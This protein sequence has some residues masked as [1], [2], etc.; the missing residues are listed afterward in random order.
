VSGTAA[1]TRGLIVAFAAASF[2]CDAPPPPEPAASAPVEPAPRPPAA[3]TAVDLAGAPVDPFAGDAKVVVLVFL[4]RDCPI[5]NKYAPELRRIR[6]E[7]AGKGVRW[8]LVF[9]DPDD[10]GAAIERH[11][12]EYEL[13]GPALQDP[14]HV[15]VRRS[16]V[17]VTP[18]AAV[19]VRSGAEVRRVYRG[20]ID[21]RWADY[22]RSRPQVRQRELVDAVAA[23]LEGRAPAAEQVAAVGCPIDDLLPSAG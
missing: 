12:G 1:A 21:D 17:E 13:P 15:L 22:G 9:P 19:F 10:D 3:P 6:D 2:G 20:R 14:Q 8:Y 5:S 7:L 16:A 23:A 4:S 18:E 11:L